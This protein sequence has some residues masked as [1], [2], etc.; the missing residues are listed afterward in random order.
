MIKHMRA[1]WIIRT[2]LAAFMIEEC[3]GIPTEETAVG[4]YWSVGEAMRILERWAK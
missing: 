2:A 4:P 1:W 3:S